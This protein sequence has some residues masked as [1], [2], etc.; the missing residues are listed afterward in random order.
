MGQRRQLSLVT[1]ALDECSAL[2]NTTVRQRFPAVPGQQLR[3]DLLTSRTTAGSELSFRGCAICD[4]PAD[5]RLLALSVNF[6][7]LRNSNAIGG[8]ADIGPIR[9]LLWSD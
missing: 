5:C 3:R 8:K 9:W 6:S 1:G 2:G 4:T 7:A